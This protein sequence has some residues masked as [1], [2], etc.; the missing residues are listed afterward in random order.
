MKVI[1]MMYLNQSK[2]PLH[3]TKISEKKFGMDY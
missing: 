3:Q 1:L 2:A